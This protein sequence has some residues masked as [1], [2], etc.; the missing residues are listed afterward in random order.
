VSYMQQGWIKLHRKILDNPVVCKDA[1]HAAVWIYLLLNAT[2]KEYTTMFGGKKITLQPGQLITGRIAISVKFNIS[3]SKVQRILKSFEIEQQIEQLMGN[4]SRLITVL[5]W[6]DYQDSEQLIEQQLNNHRTTTEHPVNTYNNVKNY[7]NEN[8]ENNISSSPN[9]KT[10]Y[11]ENDDCYKLASY[12]QM[13]IKG[14]L[15]E[16][17]KD[18]LYKE[19]NIQRWSD[20][21]RKIIE[22]DKRDIEE[23]K[24]VIDWCTADSFWQSNI[25][26]PDKLRKQYVKLALKMDAI[27][28]SG[29]YQTNRQRKDQD[30]NDILQ[31]LFEG[32]MN[33]E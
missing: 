25:L 15:F 32:E 1:D 28:I 2:H 18:H 24:R 14:Y 27:P 13:K 20:T 29:T 26:S 10:T 9:K 8:N 30:A 21:V 17:N 5:S 3:E 16:Q 11:S 4:R 12:L 7:K 19:I 6:S 22:I 31:K 23:I 33:D